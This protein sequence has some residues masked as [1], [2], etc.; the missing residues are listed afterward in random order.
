[1]PKRLYYF[2]SMGLDQRQ[3]LWEVAALHDRPV[4]T[5]KG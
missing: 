4:E 5:Y 1:M 2:G 3:V